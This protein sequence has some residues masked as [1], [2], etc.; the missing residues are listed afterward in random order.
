MF[1]ENIAVIVP[2][3]GGIQGAMNSLQ[4][5]EVITLWLSHWHIRGELEKYS[6]LSKPLS[7]KVQI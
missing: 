1:K 2:T 6:T 7:V 4:K 5:T 3:H